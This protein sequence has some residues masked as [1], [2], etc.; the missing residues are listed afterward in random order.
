MALDG[1]SVH[2]Q[3]RCGLL[4]SLGPDAEGG[5]RLTEPKQDPSPAAAV[6]AFG[7]LLPQTASAAIAVSAL[8]YFIGW[9]EASS[10]SAL[11]APWAVSMLSPLRLLQMSASIVLP[12]ALF[13][14]MSVEWLVKDMTSTRALT[15]AIN[16][17]NDAQ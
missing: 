10:Y 16:I 11:G 7:R 14:F 3:G 15:L 12:M 5:A 13:A 9:R 4:C 8:G 17:L 1:E 2:L 6:V